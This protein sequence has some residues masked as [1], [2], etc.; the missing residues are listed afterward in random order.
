[1]NV[2]LVCGSPRRK[3]GNSAFLLDALARKLAGRAEVELRHAVARP[4][5][6]NERTAELAAASDALV[7]AF[8]LYVDGVPASLH[9]AL[10][11]IGERV[12]AAGTSPRLYAVVNNGFYDARQNA[13]AVEMLWLWGDAHGLPRG[14]VVAVGAGEM[15]QVAPMGH[16]PSK[17]LGHAFDRLADDIATGCGGET[18]FVE[19]N[20]PRF[21]YRLSA[22]HMWRKQAKA[23]GLKPRDLKRRAFDA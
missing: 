7:V 5:E 14:R 20:F 23:N 18:L 17:N 10:E 4:S 16:G 22:H 12:R 2:V 15:S 13:L 11:R 3:T 1:M 9:E 21:L 19:P 6:E 8:P